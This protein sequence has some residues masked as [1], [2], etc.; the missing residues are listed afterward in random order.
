MLRPAAA[1]GL[2]KACLLLARKLAA[3]K[4]RKRRS[5]IGRPVSVSGRI[6]S[7]FP[8]RQARAETAMRR[9][10]S[11]TEC[12]RTVC[13]W[14]LL[15]QVARQCA[16]SASSRDFVLEALSEY[17]DHVWATCFP[18]VT[19]QAGLCLRQGSGLLPL[20]ICGASYCTL[21]RCLCDR[22]AHRNP[23]SAGA[24]HGAMLA[25][26]WR[27]GTHCRGIRGAHDRGSALPDS[28]ESRLGPLA[29]T[30]EASARGRYHR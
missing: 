24:H 9:G 5:A 20:P 19:R 3:G 25:T 28:V 30:A 17:L 15:V 21:E 2:A 16:A 8:R 1:T 22:G 26:G 13:G 18:F 7:L 14:G 4:L 29:G 6:L 23:V 11:S 27:G 10:I 12:H